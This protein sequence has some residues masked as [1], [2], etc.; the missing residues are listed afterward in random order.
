M[1]IKEL[2]L[3]N[4]KSFGKKAK[5]PFFDDFT[6]ISGPNGSGKSNI[7]DSILFV[8]GLSNSRIM[9][10]E[11][12][13][14]LIYNGGNGEK[15]DF[16]Q[17]SIRFDNR[18]REMPVDSDEIVITRKIRQTEAGYYSYY[19]FN[20]RPVSLSEIH[21]HL[22]KVGITP[23]GYNV[24]MQGDVT[25]IIEM[26]PTERRK[27][28]D[29]IAGV[30]EF[31]S[32]KERALNELEIV[33][34]RIER[35]DIILEEVQ[36]QLEKLREE[37]EQALKYQAL[38]EE[39]KRYEGFAFLAKLKDAEKELGSVTEDLKKLEDRKTELETQVREKEEEV[40]Q[41]TLILENLNQE[42]LRKGEEEQIALKREMEEL[43]GEISRAENSIEI[44]ENRLKEL[45]AER[46][47][48]LLEINTNRK[49]IKEIEEALEEE[50]DRCQLLQGEI[51]EREN[52]LESLHRQIAQVDAKYGETRS[53]LEELK[54][55]LEK[56]RNAKNELLREEDR[57]LDAARR[58]ASQIREL[59]IEIQE[60]QEKI[61][62]S[63]RDT[64]LAKQGIEELNLKIRKQSQ[65]S[66]DLES[67]IYRLK[68][69]I[70]EYDD[71]LHHLNQEYA[72][73]ETRLKTA[74]TGYNRT[75]EAII[76]AKRQ[77][78][79]PGIHGTIAELGKVEKKYALALEVAAGARMQAIVT[80]TDEDAAHAIQYLK[81]NRLGRATFLPLNKLEPKPKL[82]E[83]PSGAIDYALNLVSFESKFEP[84][85]WYVFRDTL[86]VEDLETARGLMGGRRMVTLEGDLIEKGGA[87]TGGTI[88]SRLSFAT[89]EEE[90]LTRIAQE[91]TEIE[92]KRK[93]SQRELEKTEEHFYHAKRE[94]TDLENEV[95][96]LKMQ[97]EEIQGR[98]DRLG[99]LIKTREKELQTLEEERHNA[100]RE[101]EELARKK[102][103]IH[104]QIQQ[105]TTRIEET[106][107]QLATSQLP[108]LTKEAEREKEEINR[109][110]SRIRDIQA[111]INAKNLEKKYT[112]QKLEELTKR[113]N[114]HQETEYQ[115]KIT[116][117]RN[118]ITELQALLQ[119]KTKKEQEIAAE[120]QELQTERDKAQK[121]VTSKN[122]ELQET[123]RKLENLER[124]ILALTSTQHALQGEIKELEEEITRLQISKEEEVPDSQEIARR[125][126]AI[127]RTM[128]SL[129]PVNMRAIEEYQ[130]VEDRQQELK[131]RRDTLKHE[132][133]E[134]IKRI[135]ECEKLKK[136]SFMEAF[137]GVNKHFKEIFAELSEGTGELILEN[138][139]DPFSGG[140]TIRAQPSEKTL[141]RLEAMS[142][143]EKS[144]TALSLI[145]AIQKYR[146]APFYAFDE[147]DMFLDGVNAERVAKHIHK[148][149]KKAQFIVV[150]LRKPMIEAA[151][152]T[153]GVAMQENNISSI[154]GM[155]LNQN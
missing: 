45:E 58:R 139:Q 20:N 65:D 155:K 74:Q 136:D 98:E 83:T 39:Q 147:I 62:N 91:I 29:E 68:A 130:Q 75:V 133:E 79:L 19:Y 47:Q 140:M 30:S 78:E 42:I 97:L 69:Q 154:T 89:S 94:L 85:F 115:Q 64:E 44:L 121:E 103:K 34:E 71:K 57:L 128:E 73:T 93:K 33:R 12:L 144:L 17:V 70:N 5:I 150:S 3:Q 53:Q 87:M 124:Q 129:E 112:Q 134:L 24:V 135:Q 15:K 23:E 31:E 40:R 123:R 32:K 82:K 86:V 151:T 119:E 2:E 14:D 113:L 149:A 81:T 116:D 131:T 67:K 107:K 96:K 49:K 41:S 27:I 127:H 132:R 26:T 108:A 152:R 54:S 141:Q 117:N 16:A 55:Q 9:R 120:L 106:E 21:D 92:S 38:R 109:L 10:A 90:K 13:T 43:R 4:F 80:A 110:Q 146:P 48:T 35:V 36:A 138:P 37:R 105:L 56:A 51:R 63:T 148:S 84:A 99:S 101:M 100:T 88:K 60:S 8:L 111:G 114:R 1:H 50:R 102:E 61:S 7:I 95:T 46:R 22:A 137:N 122:L 66:F 59:E 143:G 25:R 28:I 52:R 77:R 142:G 118:R 18:D 6:A 153:I 76:E 11:K 72:K 145:F 126:S 125:L 104:Q